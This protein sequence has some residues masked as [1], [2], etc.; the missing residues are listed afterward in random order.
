VPETDNEDSQT[1]CT[2][3]LRNNEPSEAAKTVSIAFT[4]LSLKLLTR[5]RNVGRHGI[6]LE[7]PAQAQ[8]KDLP[9][10]LASKGD[11]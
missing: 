9:S 5:G 8:F 4:G 10:L 7:L 1:V 11:Y 3:P 2:D 6:T